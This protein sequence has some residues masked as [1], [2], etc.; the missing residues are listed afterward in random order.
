[1]F[2]HLFQNIAA[3]TV[4]ITIAATV[5]WGSALQHQTAGGVKTWLKKMLI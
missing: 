3:G 1:M 4:Q 2:D 5:E